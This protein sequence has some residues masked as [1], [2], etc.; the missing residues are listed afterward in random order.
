MA[1]GLPMYDFAGWFAAPTAPLHDRA[2]ELW[3]GA[4][5][6]DISE[7]FHGVGVRAAN[8]RGCIEDDETRY[9]IE[10][11]DPLL[12]VSQEFPEQ[13]FVYLEAECFGGDCIYAGEV[14]HRGKVIGED[15]GASDVRGLVRHLGVTT[16]DGYFAP[17]DRSFDWNG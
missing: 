17:L 4:S 5:V 1:K 11:G 15:R 10:F 9:I 14:F 13:T 6:V 12:R 7:P 16:K 3:P 8:P 2:R